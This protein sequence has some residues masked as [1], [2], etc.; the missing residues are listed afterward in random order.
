VI[1]PTPVRPSAASGRIAV[2]GNGRAAL[3]SG[4]APGI[5]PA[6]VRDPRQADFFVAGRLR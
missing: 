1:S 2:S 6:D 3:F 5:V 4:D